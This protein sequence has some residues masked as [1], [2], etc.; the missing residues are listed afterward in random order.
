MHKLFA[1]AFVCI[2]MAAGGA[3]VAQPADN[4]LLPEGPGRDRVVAVC[5]SCHVSRAFAQVREN[6]NGWKNQ[7][8]EMI[9]I[10]AQVSPADMDAIVGYL[11]TAFGPGT[12]LPGP[13]S[14]AVDLPDGAAKI[15]VLGSCARCHGLDRVA[16]AKRSPREWDHIVERMAFYGAPLD[17][18]QRKTVVA[19]LTEHYAAK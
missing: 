6:A 1:S 7:V 13:P 8:S 9:L 16:G 19:Y 5:T 15:L 18:G 12:R 3:A 10:G 11:S 14:Q 17:E 2:A 4:P